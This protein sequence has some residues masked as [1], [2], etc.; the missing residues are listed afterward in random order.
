MKDIITIEQDLGDP[1]KMK[2][3]NHDVGIQ[4]ELDFHDLTTLIRGQLAVLKGYRDDGRVPTEHLLKDIATYEFILSDPAQAAQ[5]TAVYM[6]TKK[7]QNIRYNY[8]VAEYL[9]WK[10]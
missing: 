6:K 5:R 10:I 4:H 2:V 8:Q 9:G 3:T 1:T 7:D